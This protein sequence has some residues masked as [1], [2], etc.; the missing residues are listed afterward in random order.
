MAWAG[1]GDYVSSS[2]L[3]AA[4]VDPAKLVIAPLYFGP[5]NVKARVTRR[6]GGIAMNPSEKVQAICAEFTYKS[7]RVLEPDLADVCHAALTHNFA[8]DETQ[9]HVQ[10]GVDRIHNFLRSLDATITEQ[11]GMPKLHLPPRPKLEVLNTSSEWSAEEERRRRARLAS[12]EKK[13]AE[14]AQERATLQRLEHEVAE[15]RFAMGA[16]R[17]RIEGELARVRPA[18]DA[19]LEGLAAIKDEHL[20]EVRS[21][22]TPPPMVHKV[23][24]SVLTVLGTDGADRWDV[25]QSHMKRKDFIPM[26]RDFDVNSVAPARLAPLRRFIDDASFTHENA[27]HASKAAAPLRVWVVALT[28]YSEVY[29]RVK[30]LLDELERN[31]APELRRREAAVIEQRGRV[32]KVEKEL[33]DMEAALRKIFDEGE[34][35]SRDADKQAAVDSRNAALMSDWHARCEVLRQRH[36]RRCEDIAARPPQLDDEARR[37]AALCRARCEEVL[38]AVERTFRG[39][40]HPTYGE[41]AAVAQAA[42]PERHR[43]SRQSPSRQ[44]ASRR[45]SRSPAHRSKSR[46]NGR[47]TIDGVQSPTRSRNV[48]QRLF[49]STTAASRAASQPRSPYTPRRRDSPSRLGGGSPART[50]SPGRQAETPERRSGSPTL[51]AR[52]RGRSSEPVRQVRSPLARPVPGTPYRGTAVERYYLAVAL[53]QSATSASAASP[54]CDAPERNGARIAKSAPQAFSPAAV[55]PRLYAL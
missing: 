37:V 17:R 7:L 50:A 40:K 23:L 13:K 31:M 39:L 30:P 45:G 33:A 41:P 34:L 15:E 32:R 10:A 21:Y 35:R 46:S 19:A 55:A 28:E 3:G 43:P 4:Y 27:Q 16:E 54:P 52:Q 20:W 18:L 1:G 38:A 24:S 51:T 25:I 9:R 11:E 22:Q 2:A 29:A 44:S 47:A 26:V 36:T 5:K 6:E 14:A 12:I 53:R 49:D 42:S 48:Y 8:S